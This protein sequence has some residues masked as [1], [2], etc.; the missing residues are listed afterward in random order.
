MARAQALESIVLLARR[1]REICIFTADHLIASGLKVIEVASTDEAL[2][3]LECRTDIHC[4]FT[5]LDMP[6]CLSGLD[7]ARFV[8]RRWPHIGIIILGWPVQPTPSLAQAVTFLPE[9]CS[10]SSVVEQVH[11][12][13]T[14]PSR[15]T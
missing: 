2:S 1:K 5:E 15:R 14:I 7:L 11:A 3:H 9:Q 12:R 8:T 4:V 6:G 10:P 13:L